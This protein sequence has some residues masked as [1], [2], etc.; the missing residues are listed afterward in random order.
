MS[1]NDLLIAGAAIFLLMNASSF[2]AIRLQRND[3]ADVVWG[4]GFFISGLALLIFKVISD[5]SF[6][7]NTRIICVLTM[8]GMWALRLFFHIGVRNLRKSNE[9]AR[10]VKMRKA[11]GNSW[12]LKS[13]THVFMLQG[14]LMLVIDLPVFIIISTPDLPFDLWSFFGIGIWLFGFIVESLADSQLARFIKDPSNRGKIMD[15]GL[16]NWSRHPNYFG[17]IV[18]W[19]GVFFL[20]FAL[21]QVGV[22]LLS[23]LLI[24][25]L[26]LK[27]SGVTMLEDQMKN[28]PGYKEYQARTSQFIL[29]PPKI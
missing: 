22:A 19:W 18:Q 12:K 16:W 14:L 27:V 26:I 10:Y 6:Q 24:S 15:R 2:F 4:P 29:W 3:I 23:P 1:L 7:V 21:P 25:F 11:W 17:E 28:R 20:T 13:Y 5:P 9:D 8:V